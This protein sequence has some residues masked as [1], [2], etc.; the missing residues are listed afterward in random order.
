MLFTTILLLICNIKYLLK[1]KWK[2]NSEEKPL[3]KFESQHRE[4]YICII[5]I[6]YFFLVIQIISCRRWT[7]ARVTINNTWTQIAP[8]RLEL[9]KYATDVK[10]LKFI[11][12]KKNNDTREPLELMRV[13]KNDAQKVAGTSTQR[14]SLA[15]YVKPLGVVRRGPAVVFLLIIS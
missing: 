2:E 4:H 11:M 8:A 14:C 15:L 12:G 6:C 9:W 1:I 13:M 7:N 10:R 5:T 3:K